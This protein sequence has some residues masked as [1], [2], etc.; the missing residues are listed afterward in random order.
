MSSTTFSRNADWWASRSQ[1]NGGALTTVSTP[2]ADCTIM[3]DIHGIET[4]EPPTAG[5]FVWRYKSGC[6]GGQSPYGAPRPTEFPFYSPGLYCPSGQAS[7]LL[8]SSSAFFQP[9]EGGLS[10]PSV[11]PATRTEERVFLSSWLSETGFLLPEETVV[12]CCPQD[13]TFALSGW[14]WCKRTIPTGPVTGWPVG[15]STSTPGG[16]Y[17]SFVRATTS[18][19]ITF[20]PSAHFTVTYP[21]EG[22][23]TISGPATADVLQEA[24]QLRWQLSDL[25]SSLRTT[26]TLTASTTPG[27]SITTEPPSPL[28]P[29]T[30]AAIV[31]GVAFGI[32]VAVGVTVLLWRRR[33]RRRRV[34]GRTGAAGG[35]LG[36]LD[37]KPELEAA[38]RGSGIPERRVV[39]GP[40]Q[41][42]AE[43]AGGSNSPRNHAGEMVELPAPPAGNF[44]E[45]SEH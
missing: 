34:Q 11:Y 30:I 26:G 1:S 39:V 29:G 43:L 23:R 3:T 44:Y 22:V 4:S 18:T 7:V 6:S 35:Q 14:G 41:Y 24:V 31:L 5:V 33:K 25:P 10:P 17:V 45:L 2:P 38:A 37:S 32:A 36:G 13:F 40:L 12:F 42:G 27:A 16:P 15:V 8:W 28:S 9:H 19:V 21:H 20:G